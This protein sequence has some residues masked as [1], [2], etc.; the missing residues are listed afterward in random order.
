[1][2]GSLAVAAFAAALVGIATYAVV[3]LQRQEIAASKD[4]FERYKLDAGQSIAEAGARAAEANLE[5]EKFKAPRRLELAQQNRIKEKLKG[6][7]GTTFEI[8][9]YPYEPE[10]AALSR[11]I[12]ET[13]KGAAWVFNPNNHKNSLLS[14]V[15]GVTI[16][17]GMPSN[18]NT[19][20]AGRALFE[21]L[22]SE[23]I[24]ATLD[25]Q[26]LHNKPI[27]IAI[28]IRVGMKR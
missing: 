27:H 17:V 15:S 3:Q 19:D 9:T 11:D 2:V 6:F 8:V 24:A 25:F 1:M 21:A 20:E 28:E 13:L 10:P 14:P 23:G 4:E 12:V 26:M 16:T 22:T 7:H 5:L 18:A